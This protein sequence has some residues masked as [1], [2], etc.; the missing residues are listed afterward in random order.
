MRSRHARIA[1]LCAALAA[2]LSCAGRPPIPE[3]A[4]LI[5]ADATFA[6]SFD[7][8]RLLESDLYKMYAA[9][10]RFFGR[11]RINFYKFAEATG[12]DPSK[13]IERVM[14]V[15]T[16]SEEEGLSE[17]SG[18]ATGTFDGRKVHDFLQETGL[19]KE[20]VAGTDIF[21]FLVIEGRCRF[22]LAVID[23]GTA[24]FG[25]GETLRKMARIKVAEQEG[26]AMLP[27]PARLLRRMGHD[28]EFWGIARTADLK[29]NLSEILRNMSRDSSAL[30]V[31]GPI[32]EVS[33]SFDAANPMRFV[34]EM[35]ASNDRDAMLVADVLKGIEAVGRLTLSQARPEMGQMVRDLLIEADTGLVRASGTIPAAEVERAVRSLGLDGLPFSGPGTRSGAPSSSG[36]ETPR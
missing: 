16:A 18:L 23:A 22:C 2:P 14:F 12:L 28:P 11:N 10:E 34:L 35:T 3:G 36:T 21:E 4:E 30:S 20:T 27:G 31:L 33:F 32:H 24:A 5:P 13:D 15:A 26:M 9:D 6:L 19:P 1:M 7:L 8:K 29:Q 25:D 17:M